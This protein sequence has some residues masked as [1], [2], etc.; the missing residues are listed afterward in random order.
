MSSNRTAAWQGVY[1]AIT[2]AWPLISMRTFV[3]L[4][5]PKRDLWLVRTVGLLALGI[6][7]PLLR[8]AIRGRAAPETR[9]LGQSAAAAFAISDV[10]HVA[11]G[12]ISPIYLVDAAA[13]AAFLHRWR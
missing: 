11:A 12:V 5:G 7:L 6:S 1:Y 2:G 9:L 3:R 8:A 10:V 13:E 4:T